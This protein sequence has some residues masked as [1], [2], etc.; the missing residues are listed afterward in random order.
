MGFY[1]VINP[2]S[3]QAGSPEDVSQVLANFNA[4]SAVLNGSLDNT[5][6]APAAGILRSKLDFGAGLTN[7][8]IALAAAI[9]RSK[10]NFGAG[11][12]DSD[13]AAAAA[14]GASKLS[15]YPSDVTKALLGDGSWAAVLK[16][17]NLRYGFMI[18]SLGWGAAD[19]NYRVYSLGGITTVWNSGGVVNAGGYLDLSPGLWI[20]GMSIEL[21]G[22]GTLSCSIIPTLNGSILLNGTQ[23]YI[24]APSSGPCYLSHTNVVN[25]AANSY[26]QF[27]GWST[28]GG[29]KPAQMWAVRVPT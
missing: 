29:S 10:L 6:M 24:V 16:A 5:N 21:T 26:I 7:A 25:I 27:G 4:I 23:S 8:D 19:A 9:A 12:V 18:G 15:G 2:L 11:L 3:M 1:N 17:A 14:I 13:I 28:A 20:Y 22:G